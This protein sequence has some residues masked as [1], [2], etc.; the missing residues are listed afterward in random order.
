MIV[1][2]VPAATMM[3]IFKFQF[4]LKTRTSTRSRQWVASTPMI[5]GSCAAKE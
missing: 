4:F 3:I 2:S 1:R 5:Q